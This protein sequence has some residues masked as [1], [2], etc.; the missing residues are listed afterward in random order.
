[1]CCSVWVILILQPCKA[2]MLATSQS[3]IERGIVPLKRE[4]VGF[5]LAEDPGI[6]LIT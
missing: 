3:P 1:M 5:F 6:S 2:R 4:K